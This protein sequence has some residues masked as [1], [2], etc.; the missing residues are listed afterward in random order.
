MLAVGPFRTTH[1]HFLLSHTFMFVMLF[2]S[3][4]NVF[5]GDLELIY[6][7]R[8]QLVPKAVSASIYGSVFVRLTALPV[9]S[10][11]P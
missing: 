6:T 9:D 1:N 10:H 5:F 8:D 4:V 7:R 11:M 3:N 2:V